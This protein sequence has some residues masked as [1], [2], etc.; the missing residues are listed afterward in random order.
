MPEAPPH[1]RKDHFDLLVSQLNEFVV[2]LIDLEGRFTSWHPGVERL[3]GYGRGEF[4]GQYLDLLLPR[5]ERN[6][7]I[8]ER[9]LQ[10]AAREGRASDTR[11][12][13]KKSD[14]QIFVEGFTIGLRNG[15]DLA[16]FGK[17]LRDV[18]EQNRTQE[19][20]RTLAQA[21]DQTMVIIRRWDGTITYWTVGCERLYGWTAFEAVGQICQELLRTVFPASLQHIQDQLLLTGSWNG[22]VQHVR[23]DGTV[24][25]I[26]TQW[27][28]MS[29][30]GDQPP[31]VIETQTDV[32]SRSRIQREVESMNERLQN[33]ATELERSNEELAEFARIASH[34]LS[35][36]IIST[37]WLV[38][39]LASRH[40]GQLEQEGK[41]I[42][43]QITQG[44]ERMSNLVEGVLAHAT[45]GR[46]PIG[47]SEEVSADEAFDSAVEN[48]RQHIDT[49]KAQIIREKL[50]RVR[51]DKQALAQLFQN[52]LSNAI[53]Y[54]RPEVSPVIQVSASRDGSMWLFAIEDNG[55]GIEP[56]WFERIFQAMQRRHAREISGSGIGLA[57]CKKIVTRA[58][59]RIWVESKLDSGS[60]FYFTI[61]GPEAQGP[62]P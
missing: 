58:G 33:M 27:V 13:A 15:G 39:L 4:I 22:E 26:A 18:T 46:T 42:L 11:W 62:R 21:L 34:D 61:P 29:S 56:D 20:L 55:I 44:L 19:R 41:K 51:I 28:L 14:E 48:L 24:L 31:N 53:K 52:L 37:R 7:G 6:N 1:T 10:T 60:T 23:R 12:L 17:I 32:T 40:A 38:D 16:G 5:N 54:R 47:S 50:P 3:F 49:S 25:S 2:V 59:G 30:G 8:G 43:T 9:E 35:A 57:T 45:V 36:P